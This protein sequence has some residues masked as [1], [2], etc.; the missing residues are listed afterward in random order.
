MP[1]PD[2]GDG[3][4]DE[5]QEDLKSLLTEGNTRLGTGGGWWWV[6]KPILVFSLCLDQAEQ[7]NCHKQ[8]LANITSHK[9]S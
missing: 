2:D 6:S 8:K 1:V 5:V 3:L 4:S 9:W 7:L